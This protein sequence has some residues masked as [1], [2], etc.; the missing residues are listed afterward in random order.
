MGRLKGSYAMRSLSRVVLV[1]QRSACGCALALLVACG[2]GSNGAADVDE[3]ATTTQQPPVSSSTSFAT[4]ATDPFIVGTAPFTAQFSGG[5]ASGNGAWVIKP[6]QTATVFFG[7]PADRVTFTTLQNFTVSSA[8]TGSAPLRQTTRRTAAAAAACGVPDAGND[9]TQPF[10]ALMFVRGSVKNDWAAAAE[11]QLINTGGST[12]KVQ[13]EIEAGDRQFKVADAGWTGATNCGADSE[14]T[15]TALDEPFEM[16]CDALSQ[17]IEITIATTDCYEFTV[18][19]ADTTRPIVTVRKA[20]TNGNG[21]PPPAAGTVI[22]FYDA[23]GALI[24]TTEGTE[25]TVVDE[26]RRGAESR[27][28]RIEIQNS[29]GVGD[30]GVEDFA[31]VSDPRFTLAQRTISIFY[32]NLTGDY[33]NTRISIGGQTYTC[34]AQTGNEVFGCEASGIPV[35]PVTEISFTVT[36]ADN[37]TETITA[38]VGDGSQPLYGFQGAP[39]AR[40][41]APGEAGASRPAIPSGA[42]EVILFYKR[43]DNSYTGWGLHLFPLTPSTPVWTN[44]PTPGEYLFEGIDPTYGAY[45]RIGLPQDVSPPYS[46]DPPDL[47]AF[48]TEL[49]FI[50]HKGDQKD[51]GPDQVIRIAQ[52]G[53][54]IFV[55]SGINDVASAPPGAVAFRVVG[56]AAHWV[57][58]STL[59]WTP[60][61]GVT[62]IELLRS[63]DASMQPGTSGITGTYQTVVLG[64]GTNPMLPNMRHLNSLRAWSLPAAAVNEAQQIAREQLI[65]VGRNSANEIVQATR[66]QTAG[67]LDDLYAEAAKDAELGPTYEGG[68][69]TLRVWAPTALIDPGV[70]VRIFNAGSGGD[71]IETIAMTLDAATGV[72]SVAGTAAWDRRFYT[73]S[74]RT[75]SYAT[76]S[77]ETN[78]V[79]DPYSISLSTDSVRS[80]FVN[81]DDTDLKP[82]GWDTLTK[83]ALARPEDIVLYE[84][85]VR[86][87]SV[88]D[89]SVPGADRGKYTAFAVADSNGRNHLEALGAAGLTHVHVLPAFD[90]ATVP[91]NPAD[92]VELDDPASELCAAVPAAASL[93]A[94]NPGKTLRQIMDEA[95]AARRLDVPQQIV[96]WLRGLD[97]FNWGYDPLH[98]G[99]PEGSYATNANG[100]QRVLEFR[101]MVTGLAAAGL[102][103]VMDVV[104]N[105]TN[106]AGQSSR[107][108]LD[109]I[110]PGYYHRRNQNTGDVLGDSCCSDTATEFRMM[111]KLMSD[112]LARWVADYKVDGFRF[113]IMGFHTLDNITNVRTRLAAIN[114]QIYLYGEGWNFGD[115]Q[116]DR[117]FVQARQANLGG[118]GVGS[119]SDRIRDPIRGGGPFDSGASH[120][121]NQGFISGQYYAPNARNSGAESEKTALLSG[122]DNIRLWMA[123]GLASYLLVDKEGNEVR[124][125]AVDYAGQDSGY[126]QDPQE[127][128]NYFEAHDNETLWDISQYKHPGGTE[129]TERVQAQNLAFS[130]ALLSQGIP[131]IHA[132]SEILRSKSQD[133]NSYDSGDWFNEVDWT[134][135]T[136]RW[137]KGLPPQ[138]DNANNWPF[139]PDIVNDPTT[140]PDAAARQTTLNHVLEMLRI[141]KSSPLFRL[142]NQAEV[143]QRVRFFNTGP[144]QVPGVIAMSID[145]CTSP[146]VVAS[147]AA[148]MVIVNATT[149]PRTLELFAGQTWT[150]HPDQ[151]DTGPTYDTST[152][153]TVP[154]RTTGVFV[155]TAPA[156]VSCQPLPR[157][158]F[159]RGSFTSWAASP[160]WRFNFLGGKDYSVRGQVPAGAQEFKVADANWTDGTNCGADAS[161]VPSVPVELACTGN[162]PNIRF[163]PAAAGEYQFA[164]DTTEA[165]TPVLT[166]HPAPPFTPEIYVRGLSNDWGTPPSRRL[167]WDGVSKYQVVIADLA[168]GADDFKIADPGWSDGTNCGTGAAFALDTPLTLQCTGNSPNIQAS[169]PQF[170]SYLFSLDVTAPATPA[171]TVEQLPFAATLFLRG[172]QGQWDAKPVNRM[173][174]VGGDAYRARRLLPTGASEFKVADSG[175]SDGTNCGA[176]ADVVPGTPVTLACTG[177]QPNLRFTPGA[178]GSYTFSLDVSTPAAPS[179]TVSTP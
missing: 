106:A 95:V 70:S 173:R 26:Q 115:V 93:C 39:N 31:W 84:L 94:A 15:P 76:D 41:G 152:G 145:G 3:G 117:R 32:R 52:D 108:V 78:E 85:H 175:W 24:K 142:P 171:L 110:V 151:T 120:I 77:I 44:F 86:D 126:T 47:A 121:A 37:S 135:A 69:P 165:T 141:R 12:L 88:A 59:L 102:R 58:A 99:A 139:L 48:P 28:A 19:A 87:F 158:V 7:T 159:V 174:Y 140:A 42:N 130:I 168:A 79:T 10:G 138:G 178:A 153:F 177:N 103:T 2:S 112:T 163:A 63:A 25:Q 67:A 133:R 124:G 82:A 66:V 11:N 33:S 166:V 18:N 14:P 96:G 6:N 179:L 134:R 161:L 23:A 43:D 27:I 16:I 156:Q 46:A 172:L 89:S 148:I 20:P 132:G 51:P 146:D 123:G 45:Y 104:Y 53:N 149:V 50:I 92:R 71:P 35:Q 17:N 107:S 137:N 154:A 118:T 22:R 150:R 131:F 119:F 80:Q 101:T 129:L 62:R 127:A 72:W 143:D 36:N 91:E 105:H 75:Y 162:Q 49:G 167:V 8:P 169:L 128:I 1:L 73:I 30:I 176:D 136:S 157:D 164:L 13:L 97:G 98:Y 34:I 54:M 113:D 61:N 55:T 155:R 4:E 170:G 40:I 90:L 100:E 64:A 68:V 60:E 144:F 147:Q 57:T 160:E 9:N 56:A 122:T 65:V 21:E 114:P 29:G 38:F 125:D 116:N 111:E 83:P 74:L 81:L 109:R 5:V